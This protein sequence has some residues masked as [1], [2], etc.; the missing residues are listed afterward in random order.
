M[1]AAQ[2]LLQVR[3]LF[4]YGAAFYVNTRH[5][6]VSVLPPHGQQTVYQR[7][8]TGCGPSLP[9]EGGRLVEKPLA[10]SLAQAHI[11]LDR[12]FAQEGDPQAALLEDHLGVVPAGE[13]IVLVERK[14][15]KKEGIGC[16]L[17]G[18]RRIRAKTGVVVPRADVLEEALHQL[19]DLVV[20][21]QEGE[22]SNR[23]DQDGDADCR[24]HPKHNPRILHPP[25]LALIR[26]FRTTNR[27]RA[28]LSDGIRRHFHTTSRSLLATSRW[29]LYRGKPA[30]NPP[31][32]FF[33]GGISRRSRSG[34]Y[35][36]KAHP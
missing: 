29:Y 36:L 27:A 6:P 21:P 5:H 19:V 24:E 33:P 4:F 26:L 23:A 11:H 7:R 10:G 14:V 31:A 12:S 2:P 16:I 35:P 1:L 34:A 32:T 13:A 20:L 3:I 8:L 28:S 15:E 18:S 22:I 9:H 25:L 17:T 30:I